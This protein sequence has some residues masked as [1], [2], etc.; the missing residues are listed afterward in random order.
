MSVSWPTSNGG[1]ATGLRNTKHLPRLLRVLG[2]SDPPC[3]FNPQ[4]TTSLDPSPPRRSNA[5]RRLPHHLVL[6]P[7][8]SSSISRSTQASRLRPRL[9][10]WP[11]RVFLG[12]NFSA[13]TRPVQQDNRA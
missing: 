12:F 11:A 5:A 6:H 2:L 10:P 13:P 4:R 3:L 1:N 9:R 8:R 7:F